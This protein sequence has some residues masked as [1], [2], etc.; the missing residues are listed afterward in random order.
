MNRLRR[1]HIHTLWVACLVMIGTVARPL[2]ASE[3][4]VA[5]TYQ[6]D[7]GGLGVGSNVLWPVTA[8]GAVRLA[9]SIPSDLQTFQ[10][11][12]LVLIPS[13][14]TSATLTLYLCPA[15]ATQMVTSNCSGP[16]TQGFTG[17]AN[18]LLEVDVTAAVAAHLGTPG[19]SYLSALAFT[20]PTTTT[21]HISVAVCTLRRRRHA[22]TTRIVT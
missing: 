10:S 13:A 7:L 21:D 9:W 8:T 2:Q 1:H 15:Q 17:V 18:Q 14:S 4:W 11:A 3:I 5:P 12:K 6:Q 20:T 19:I 22:S 16:F